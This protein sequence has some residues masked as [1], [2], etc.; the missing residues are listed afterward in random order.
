MTAALTGSLLGLE[1][2]LLEKAAVVG[3]STALSAGSVWIPNSHHAPAGSDSLDRARRYLRATVG[4]RLRPALCEGF[5]AAGPP[6]VRFLEERSAVRLRAYRHHPDYL[7]EADGATLAGRALEPRALRRP[8]ARARFPAAARP[9][10]GVHAARR[11]DGRPHRHRAAA[12]RHALA[13]LARGTRCACSRA[14]AI[15]RLRHPPGDAPGDGQRARRP[16]AP[17][18]AQP[19]R[20]DPDAGGG[21]GAGRAPGAD[22]GRGAGGGTAPPP[23]RP[24]R[25]GVG[26]RRASRATRS[27]AGDL[28]PEPD[29]RAFAAGRD[30]RPGTASSSAARS[31]GG[32][33]RAMPTR[34]SG[35]RSRSA[36]RRDGSTAVFPHFVLDRGKPGLIAVDSGGRRFVNEATT[37]HRFGQ[38]IYAAHRV[39]PAIP[40]CFVC[41][42]RFIV[43]YGLGMVRPRGLGLRVRR[44]R[45]LSDA[46]RHARRPRRSA[47][48]RPARARAD[49]RAP[50]RVRAHRRRRSTSPRAATP[51]SATSA[52]RRTGPIPASA[53]STR[54]RSTR[55][56]STPATSAPA[57]VW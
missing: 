11:H 9:V 27:C 36:Q 53:R 8:P 41:D 44:G 40:C 38:A 35:R 21:R 42:H 1:V 47:R 57:S 43:S 6:M 26:D 12:E 22:R 4:D 31:A 55:S 37:Y 25:R 17:L 15:D 30:G 3:G 2:E 28:L 16:A 24:P 5:L 48:H 54:R 7:A 29:A 49:G 18:A 20:R 14:T 52:T 45:R 32:S 23:A 13:R 34:P 19:E 46:G 56:G 50:Q 51:T 39:R 10:A 33:G